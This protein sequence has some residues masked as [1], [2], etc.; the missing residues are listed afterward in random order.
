[1]LGLAHEEN[2]MP[3]DTDKERE[4]VGPRGT[5]VAAAMRKPEALSNPKEHEGATEDQISE[6]I[7][8]AGS[9]FDDEPKQG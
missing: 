2:T 4:Q 3:P 5:G 1:L 8:P 9:A 7:A 6:T